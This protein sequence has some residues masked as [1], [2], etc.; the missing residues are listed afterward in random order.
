MV[1]IFHYQAKCIGCNACVEVDK[2]RWRMS[3]KDGKS[4][5]IK[6]INKKGIYRAEIEN[7]EYETTMKAEKNCPVKII[8]AEKV[9]CKY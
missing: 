4:T 5:L 6:G 1:K 7:D 3:R 8:K 2:N 9:K